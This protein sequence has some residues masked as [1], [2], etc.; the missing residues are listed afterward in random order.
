M[1]LTSLI[2]AWALFALACFEPWS[3]KM[4]AANDEAPEAQKL[5]QQAEELTNIRSS[6]SRSFGLAARVQ[7][8]DGKDFEAEGTYNLVWESPTVW[9]DEI[10]FADYSQ[11]RVAMVDK[12]FISRNPPILPL[13]VFRLL[14]LLEFPQVLH[15]SLNAKLGKVK[16]QRRNGSRERTIEIGSWIVSLDQS[17]PIPTRVEY[18]DSHFGYQFEDYVSFD[19]HQFP[20]T[21][22]EFASNRPLVKVQ[23]QE[24][25]E[26]TV[27]A[28][29]FIPPHDASVFRW[30]PHPEPARLVD[31][32]N[33]YAMPPHLRDVAEQHVVVLYGIIGT[34]GRWHNLAV[35]KS[36]G[37]EIDSYWMN[38]KLQERYSP[39]KC[40]GV[41]VEQESVKELHYEMLGVIVPH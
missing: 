3:A 1:R 40:G 33:L 30:C 20:R 12:L 34:D 7:L 27:D 25:A 9:R 38:Q 16:E 14:G 2:A 24:L 8:Y 32:D 15:P 41:S 37:K 36:A 18:K 26:A 29:S 17:S 5:L 10:K 13:E 22:T 6:G 23:V 35:V 39:A 4:T 19:G 21:L 31:R 11:V 28:S